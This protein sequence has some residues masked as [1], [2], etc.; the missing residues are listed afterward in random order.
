MQLMIT[1]S[2]HGDPVFAAREQDYV[3]QSQ[4]MVLDALKANR[5]A[6]VLVGHG[7]EVEVCVCGRFLK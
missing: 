7:D 1:Q 5:W 3:P 2:A 6:M 4:W